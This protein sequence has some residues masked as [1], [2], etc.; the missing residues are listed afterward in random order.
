[1][2]SLSTEVAAVQRHPAFDKRMIIKQDVA[3]LECTSAEVNQPPPATAVVDDSQ[4]LS[5]MSPGTPYGDDTEATRQSEA[6][7]LSSCAACVGDVVSKDDA[8]LMEGFAMFEEAAAAETPK[9]STDKKG[10]FTSLSLASIICNGHKCPCNEN[11]K[12]TYLYISFRF[13][14]FQL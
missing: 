13:S 5:M 11:T 8:G 12:F 2:H 14:L 1:M 6:S 9:E 3:P 10:W 4:S 7:T